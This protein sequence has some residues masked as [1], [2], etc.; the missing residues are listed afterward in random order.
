MPLLGGL[1]VIAFWG[2][3]GFNARRAVFRRMRG[4]A[5]PP[6]PKA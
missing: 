5:P 2:P 4:K 6:A 3:A 1:I